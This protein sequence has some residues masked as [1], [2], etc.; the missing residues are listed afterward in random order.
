M[1]T[2]RRV[3]VFSAGCPVCLEAV[4]EVKGIACPSCEVSVLD[5]GDAEVAAR[6]RRLGVR[7]V[8]AVAVDGVLAPCC[9][10]GGPDAATLRAAGIGKAA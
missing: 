3:E 6:A 8:P 10:G 1:T 2:R 7:A 4:A 5:L 9:G